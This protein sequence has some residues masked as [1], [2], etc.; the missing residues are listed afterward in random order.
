M[1][2]TQN[3]TKMEGEKETE[4]KTELD[5]QIYQQRVTSTS[6]LTV[7]RCAKGHMDKIVDKMVYED[8][9]GTTWYIKTAY[10]HKGK[11][12]VTCS[13]VLPDECTLE[14][15]DGGTPVDE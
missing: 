12:Y 8:M 10:K 2:T 15:I 11:S 4:M 7:M 3:Y 6:G 5:K 13:A 14:L 9:N 1:L